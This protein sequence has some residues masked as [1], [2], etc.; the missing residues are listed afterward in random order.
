MSSEKYIQIN[1]YHTLRPGSPIY[2]C[3]TSTYVYLAGA[4]RTNRRR[5]DSLVLGRELGL[6]GI[7]DAAVDLQRPDQHVCGN[8]RRRAE[9]RLG[10]ELYAG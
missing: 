10:E 4:D 2:W 1:Q 6:D 8:R 9:Q 5:H 3:S 7:H